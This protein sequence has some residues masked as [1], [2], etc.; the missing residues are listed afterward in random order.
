M[1]PSKIEVK[2]PHL[3]QTRAQALESHDQS[4]YHNFSS[5]NAKAT[6]DIEEVDIEA[7]IQAAKD[8]LKTIRMRNQADHSTSAQAGDAAANDD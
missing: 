4:D 3:E 6:K 2:K 8:L 7:Q 5:I 1:Q